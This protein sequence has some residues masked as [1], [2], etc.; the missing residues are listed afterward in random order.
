MEIGMISTI[1]LLMGYILN[2][3]VS[4]KV[5]KTQRTKKRATSLLV[6][7][8]LEKTW[9]DASVCYKQGGL[10]LRIL[11][12]CGAHLIWPMSCTRVSL[13]ITWSLRMK[14]MKIFRN[15]TFQ[16]HHSLLWDGD[17]LLTTSKLAPKTCKNRRLIILCGMIWFN[18][19]G[20]REDTI[21]IRFHRV[22]YSFRYNNILSF[23]FLHYRTVQQ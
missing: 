17:S 2:G 4:C 9:K 18:I 6:R 14:Q 11:A 5:C 22:C 23:N 13:C 20:L 1:C 3:V 15:W 12:D 10:W 21:M 19:C 7:N 8:L 16:A